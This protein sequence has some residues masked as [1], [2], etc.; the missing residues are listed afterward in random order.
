MTAYKGG[1]GT[2]NKGCFGMQ[3]LFH[4]HELA[5]E[6]EHHGRVSGMQ[7]DTAPLV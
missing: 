7:E 5:K 6:A 2:P 4:L 1:I 3:V